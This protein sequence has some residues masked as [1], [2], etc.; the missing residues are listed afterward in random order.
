MYKIT[1]N[2]LKSLEIE[3]LKGRTKLAQ[4]L[5]FIGI[6][7]VGGGLASIVSI[8]IT[9]AV[10]PDSLNLFG[11]S[12]ELENAG[13]MLVF[14]VVSSIL[15]Y[16]VVPY[17]YVRNFNKPLLLKLGSNEKNPVSV[18]LYATLIICL[19]MPVVFWMVKFNR[20]LELPVFMEGIE[21]SMR[22][23]EAKAETLTT[24]F[25]QT[26]GVW[27]IVALIGLVVI[28]GIGEE[29]LF[30]GV[31]QSKFLQS[32]ASVHVSIW[33]TAFIFSFIHFQF[34][35]FLPRMVLGAMFGYLYYYS[36]NL[37]VPMFAH[38]LNNLLAT[39]E[40]RLIGTDG[41]DF[42]NLPHIAGLALIGIY[43][44]GKAFLQTTNPLLFQKL[45]PDW[46]VLNEYPTEAE[47]VL[48]IQNLLAHDI[49][50]VKVNK[51]DSSYLFGYFQVKVPTHLLVKAQSIISA[52]NNETE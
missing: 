47:A 18:F 11:G 10:F 34:Y 3:S 21:Y 48:V 22:M 40:M 8:F 42:T 31:I 6:M 9:V 43:F 24:M 39:L 51:R 23:A 7:M 2:Y 4:W 37:W 32:G 36:G 16:L 45:P 50:A 19:S 35:G 52:T 5:I 17:L 25:V 33:A 41:L 30:R 13:A 12:S 27:F 14:Q 44:V 26:N 29:F 28:P 38:A 49:P 15:L 1:Q 20:L 46:V